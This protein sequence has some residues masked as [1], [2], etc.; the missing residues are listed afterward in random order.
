MLLH[1]GAGVVTVWL[2]VTL[3]NVRNKAR[4]R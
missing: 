1:A 3:I 2:L 4:G